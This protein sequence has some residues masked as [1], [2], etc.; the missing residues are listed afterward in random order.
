MEIKKFH[1]L[2][3]LLTYIVLG[4]SPA[5]CQTKYKLLPSFLSRFPDAVLP[6]TVQYTDTE[7]NYGYYDEA[8][9]EGSDSEKD[10]SGIK[11]TTGVGAKPDSMLIDTG[12]VRLFLLSD[13]EQVRLS[14][15][16]EMQDTILPDY[17]A[18]KKYNSGQNFYMV[19][20]EKRYVYSGYPVSQRYLCTISK[21]GNY[22]D[23]IKIA[24]AEYSGTYVLDDGFRAP[25]FPDEKSVIEKSLK[26]GL[27]DQGIGFITKA[28]SDHIEL[29]ADKWY[30]IDVNGRIK[31]Q[32]EK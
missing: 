12:L 7:F 23:K 28:G 26:I 3:G 4:I 6:D 15:T 16:D 29:N 13:S 10:T 11:Y 14:V 1:F 8:E 18:I 31:L 25:W 20:F 32:P 21:A 30:Q 5:A 27:F 17:Y 9:E 22:I 2:L 24:S 19:I